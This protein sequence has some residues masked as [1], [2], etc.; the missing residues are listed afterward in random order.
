MEVLT[1]LLTG[2]MWRGVAQRA[3]REWLA[4]NPHLE[5]IEY[6]REGPQAVAFLVN[7]REPAA[8]LTT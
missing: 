5:L 8:A 3:C 7:L 4:R 1:K 6:W 2:A